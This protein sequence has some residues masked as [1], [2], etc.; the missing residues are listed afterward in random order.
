MQIKTTMRYQFIPAKM[1]IKNS[2]NHKCC[3]GCGEKGTLLY[4]WLNCYIQLLNV[5]WYS[6]SGEQ[7]G[8]S[9][10]NYT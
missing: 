9:L 5:N 10:K 7:Y 3:K 8:G 4:C 6:H 2:T 1:A